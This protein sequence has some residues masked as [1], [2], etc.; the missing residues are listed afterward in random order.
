[1]SLSQAE[2]KGL[3]ERMSTTVVEQIDI[4]GKPFPDAIAELAETWHKQTGHQLDFDIVADIAPDK[5]VTLVANNVTFLL[6]LDAACQQGGSILLVGEGE[7]ITIASMR[8]PVCLETRNIHIKN[9]T[10]IRM[11]FQSRPPLD[12]LKESL[13]K[14]GICIRKIDL[15]LPLDDGAILCSGDPLEVELVQ[16]FFALVER[17]YCIEPL[18]DPKVDG[19]QGEEVDPRHEMSPFSV[20]QE[21]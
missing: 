20:P 18:S 3:L 5:T 1:M 21:K 14:A 17:G 15:G 10:L 2:A 4:R 8:P 16:A 7:R 12:S 11:G 19:G 9:E 6:A 13:A